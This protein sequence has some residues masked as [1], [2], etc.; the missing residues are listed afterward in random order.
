MFMTTKSTYAVSPQLCMD[1]LLEEINFLRLHL[2]ELGKEVDGLTNPRLVE[3]SQL[4]DKKLNSF[5][6][7]NA[8]RK[9]Q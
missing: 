4:L 9:R 7:L 3:V 8:G 2:Y 6:E 1:T 5:H